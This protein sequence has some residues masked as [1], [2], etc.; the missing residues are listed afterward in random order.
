MLLERY[1]RQGYSIFLQGDADGNNQDI[2]QQ[3]IAKGAV[4][5]ERTFVFRHDFETSVPLPLLFFALQQL[6]EL[7]DENRDGFKTKVAGEGSIGARLKSAYGLDL[8]PLKMSLASQ[9]AD[10]L[11]SESA[12]WQDER[13]MDTE[14]GRFLEF[15]TH[16]V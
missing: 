9:I 3:I 6:G 13:F 11:N 2:F 7:S 10:V 15:I 16:V 14:L 4:S 8:E 12:W 1:T 5:K